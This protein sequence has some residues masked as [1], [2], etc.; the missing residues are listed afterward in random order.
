[1]PGSSCQGE[2]GFYRRICGEAL[3]R[4]HA[5]SGDRVALATYLGK[6]NRFDSA[7]ADF[8]EA[9]AEQNEL[10]HAELVRAAEIG[11]VMAET[12]N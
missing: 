9:Y 3:A 4:A 5:R 12:G 7:V 8:S 11:R 6:S 2:R 10:D 1:M